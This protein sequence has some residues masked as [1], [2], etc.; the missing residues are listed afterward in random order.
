MYINR[1]VNQG[2]L[3]DINALFNI[4]Q[5]I[6]KK[7]MH[8]KIFCQKGHLNIEKRVIAGV[9]LT[10]PIDE[11]QRSGWGTWFDQDWEREVV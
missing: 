7:V 2:P 9:E 8:P 5:I 11:V 6:R 3:Y 1:K 4:Q 10:Y